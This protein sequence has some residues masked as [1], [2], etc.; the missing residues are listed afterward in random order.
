MSVLLST[1]SDTNEAV[2]EPGNFYFFQE[3]MDSATTEIPIG[4]YPFSTL[5]EY[6]DKKLPPL[7]FS[8]KEAELGTSLF[9]LFLGV[10]LMWG[11]FYQT[12]YK[13]LQNIVLSFRSNVIF[14]QILEERRTYNSIVSIGLFL[15]GLLVVATFIYHFVGQMPGVDSDFSSF[16]PG[17][18]GVIVALLIAYHFFKAIVLSL[19]SFIFKERDI[20]NAYNMLSINSMQVLGLILFPI[21]VLLTYSHQMSSIWLSIIGISIIGLFFV[22]RLLR[23]FILGVKETK[24]QVFHI[25]L[26]ICALEILPL[27]VIGKLLLMKY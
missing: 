9:W 13:T 20:F 22:Y 11:F 7:P 24:S 17:Y 6:T 1:Y 18:V 21:V 10:V 25:I 12:N 27:F 5:G 8:P 19:S 2:S 14:S 4:Q 23:S 3:R 15:S 16:S 26:Y